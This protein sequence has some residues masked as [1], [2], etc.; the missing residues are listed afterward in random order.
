MT[1]AGQVGLL[2]VHS[3]AIMV[4]MLLLLIVAGLTA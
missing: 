1:L 2:L 4:A 3:L